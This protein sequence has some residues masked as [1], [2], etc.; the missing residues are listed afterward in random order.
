MMLFDC[1]RNIKKKKNSEHVK[2]T[3]KEHAIKGKMKSSKLKSFQYQN[4]L[5]ILE[6]LR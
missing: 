1:A 5:F 4:A 3:L 2:L 6:I